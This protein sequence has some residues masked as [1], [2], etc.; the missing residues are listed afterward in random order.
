MKRSITKSLE[1]W[2]SGTSRKPLLLKGA[3]QI[4]KSYSIR[5][6][7]ENSF[8]S[9]VEVNLEENK[10][11]RDAFA[12]NDPKVIC[13]SIAVQLNQPIIPGE[14]LLFIDEIQES[15]E[16]FLALRYFYE[17]LPELH[18][19]AAGSLLDTALDQNQDMKVPVGRIEYLYMFPL[20]FMEFLHALNESM[21]H[22]F[23]TNMSLKVEVQ[24]STHVR[25]LSLFNQYIICGGMPAVIVEYTRLSS[26]LRYK[27]VQADLIQSYQDDFRKYRTKIDY[28]KIETIY[29][30]LARHISKDFKLNELCA[31]FSQASTKLILKLLNSARIIHSV[32]CSIADGMPLGAQ[33]REKKNKYL[34]LDVGLLNSLLGVT[35]LEL[36][37]W[38]YDLINSGTIAEQVVGQELLA[39]SDS[40]FDPQLYFWARDKRGSSAEVDYL[41]SHD[42]DVL[43]IE[44]K[45][46]ATGSLKS[47]R[48]FMEEKKAPFGIRVS[49]H[50]LSF[51]EQILSIPIYAVCRIRELVSEAKR[52]G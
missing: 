30:N 10:Q 35:A 22:D 25:L 47:M 1:D 39:Y 40:L 46:G 8:K 52:Q 27:K 2:K 4:G 50:S 36:S 20:S 6:F 43:P 5:E 44:V 14:T 12:T 24:D 41:I 21:A 45:A 15:K 37:K 42:Q 48:I 19:I 16:A 3:R 17:K 49:Q 7:G 13:S 9:M 31:D 34:F 23:I 26:N 32:R 33:V 38:N 51:H 11:L 28:E 29:L 18:V